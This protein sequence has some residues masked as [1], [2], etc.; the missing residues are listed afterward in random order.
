MFDALVAQVDGALAPELPDLYLP[1]SPLTHLPMPP[2][3]SRTPPHIVSSLPNPHQV[4]G[5]LAP[6]EELPDSAAATP[7]ATASGYR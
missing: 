4:N 7:A 2:H 6:E 3:L 1:T 5:A